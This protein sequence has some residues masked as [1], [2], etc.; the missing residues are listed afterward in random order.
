MERKTRQ[1]ELAE[2][3]RYWEEQVQSWRGSGL[4]QKEYCRQYQLPENRLTYWK[5]RFTKAETAVSFVQVQV[6]GGVRSDSHFSQG[7]GLRLIVGKKH[8]IEV[9][10]GFDPHVLWQLIHVLEGA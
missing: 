8:E 9:D 7:S 6:G 4:S 1:A 2:K 5:K 10:R 3:R